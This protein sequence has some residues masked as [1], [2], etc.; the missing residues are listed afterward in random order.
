MKMPVRIALLV[1]LL[2]ALIATVHGV[3]HHRLEI[4]LNAF[5]SAYVVLVITLGPILAAVLLWARRIRPG[6]VILTLSMAGSLVFGLYWHYLAESPDNVFHLHEGTL[7]S[8]FSSTALLLAVS[9]I[10]GVVVGLWGILKE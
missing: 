9:E 4:T 10:C 3:A 7:Q 1:V 6:F 5:Q 2:H 8:W